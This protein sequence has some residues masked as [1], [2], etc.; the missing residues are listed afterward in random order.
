MARN[1]KRNTRSVKLTQRGIAV[2]A[3]VAGGLVLLAAAGHAAIAAIV[4]YALYLLV[5]GRGRRVA[6]ILPTARQ[7]LRALGWTAVALAVTASAQGTTA[8]G[9]ATLGVALAVALATALKL[10]ATSR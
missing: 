3:T 5:S 1:V 2:I 4:G 9:G 7:A 6:R 8:P 10:T